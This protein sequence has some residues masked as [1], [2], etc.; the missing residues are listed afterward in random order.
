V[1][2][3]LPVIGFDFWFAFTPKWSINPKIEFV[4]GRYQ[5]VSAGVLSTTFLT[6]YQ[7]NRP[8]GML[9]GIAYFNAEVKIE[10]SE[11]RID[12]SYGYNGVFMGLHVVL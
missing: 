4:G 10:G 9:F 3:P 2:A 8:L 7:F 11:E 6:R 1:L 5:D 12:I